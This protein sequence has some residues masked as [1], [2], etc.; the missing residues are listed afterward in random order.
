MNGK[1]KIKYDLNSGHKTTLQECT[2]F[3][4]SSNDSSEYSSTSASSSHEIV[5]TLGLKSYLVYL[6][7][8]LASLENTCED[9]GFTSEKCE[10]ERVDRRNQNSKMLA[11]DITEGER[12]IF[13]YARWISKTICH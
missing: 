9:G 6:L 8:F 13:G 1:N 3:E 11:L 10:E 12:G 7:N 2:S 4:E 5:Q